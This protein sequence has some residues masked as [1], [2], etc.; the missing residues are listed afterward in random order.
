MGHAHL[1]GKTVLYLIDGLFSGVHPIDNA[2][3]R[4]NSPPFQGNWASSL[5]ASQDPVAIDSVGLDFLRAEWDDYPH[6]PAP[7]T[8]CMK[9]PSRTI[10]RRG[11]STIPIMP[12]ASSDSPAW[13]STN[14]G[15]IRK[16]RSTPAIWESAKGSN[17]WQRN[18]PSRY[19]RRIV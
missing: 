14:T 2:P 5:L 1:G 17:W 12:S 4:W 13:V 9:P 11:R 3:R 16:T 15:T 7:T 8:T 19:R 10:R 6:H 18:W